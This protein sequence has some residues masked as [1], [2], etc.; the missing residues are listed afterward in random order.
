M[1]IVNN[2]GLAASLMWLGGLFVFSGMML[3]SLPIVGLRLRL[4]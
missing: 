2:V 3:F 4:C 1:L